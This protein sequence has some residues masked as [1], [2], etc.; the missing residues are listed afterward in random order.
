MNRDYVSLHVHSTFSLLDGFGLPNQIVQRVKDLGQTA[1]AI[2]EH[3]NTSSHPKLEQACKRHGI[4]PI[5]GCEFYVAEEKVRRKNHI[6][7]LAKNLEGYKN[8]LMLSTLSY[9][10][11]RFYY[12]PTIRITDLFEHQENLIVLSGCQSGLVAREVLEGTMDAARDMAETLKDNLDD[13]YMEMQP[14]TLESSC[15]ANKGLISIAS[16]LDIPLVATTDVHYIQA[17]D[18]QAQWF[19]SSVRRRKSV[20]DKWGTMD[21]HCYLATGDEMVSW[22]APE[23]AVANTVAIA[24]MVEAFDLPKA[25]PVKYG[26]EKPYEE[27]VNLCREGWV[28]RKIPKKDWDEYLARM[29]RELDLI[30]S[31]QFTDYFLV[32]GDLVRWSKEQGIMIGTA[33]GSAA[34]SLVSYLIGITEVDPIEWDLLFERFIDVSRYDYPDIDLDFQSDRRDEAKDYLRSKYGYENVANIAGYSLFKEKSLLDDIGRVFKIPRTEIAEAKDELIENG[35]TKSAE[36]IIK[37]RWSDHEYLCKIEGMVR[38]LTIHAAGVIVA[39]DKLENYTTLG[40]DGAIML[41]HRDAEYLGLMKIDMLSLKTL[42][43]LDKCLGAIGKDSEWLYNEVP[44]DDPQTY[45]AFSTNAFQGV[46]QFEG[47]TTKRVCKQIKPTKFLELIDINALSRPGPMQSGATDAY[48]N[49][50]S[51]DIH[52]IVTKH[53]ARSRGQILFQEQIMKILKEAG[54][55]DWVDVTTVRKLITKKQ[56]AELLQGIKDRF[57]GNFPNDQELGEEIWKRCGE[58]G[59]YGFNVAHSTSYTFLGY[60]CMYLKMHYPLE[61]YWANLVVEPDKDSLLREYIQAGGE[62]FDVKVGKSECDWT[63]DRGGLRAGYLTVKG[64]GPKTALKLEDGWEPTGKV[65]K[66]LEEMGA[67]AP[68]D[69]DCDYLGLDKLKAKLEFVPLRD[70]ID[71]IK[72]GDRVRIAGKVV[73]MMVKN[74]Q[75]VIEAQGRE[76]DVVDPDKKLYVHMELADETGVTNVTISRFMYDDI[77]VQDE[78]SHLTEESVLVVT[79]EYNK[80]YQKIYARKVRVL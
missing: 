13:F 60:Y 18:E 26:I 39:S 43:I 75:E 2:T 28:K 25:E 78:L 54:N 3:G 29:N 40:R 21:E 72:A 11:D 53:T 32:V 57:V 38:Q 41:D 30:E 48:I 6:T 22:G 63:I 69:N 9:T 20:H 7:V 68:E 74:L 44:L 4:K 62:V 50:M 14:L 24:D 59:A 15:T 49:N 12:F 37:E 10:E 1:V 66:T 19:L 34:G 47:A 27:L 5:Y 46:F 80:Q 70:K 42:T 33:R 17:G 79:G 31:K 45:A 36:E 76:Y 64:I 61:F 16:E 51:E 52:P 35:G 77:R 8:L 58:S 73:K 23:Q 55:L 67:F 65:K 71:K 56:G